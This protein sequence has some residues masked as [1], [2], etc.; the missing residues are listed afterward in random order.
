MAKGALAGAKMSL[1]IAVKHA[2]R[3]RQFNDSVKIQEDLLL[4][5]P[6]HQLRLLPKVATS[7][8]YE[9]A[10]GTAMQR[11]AANTSDD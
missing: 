7:Y 10:L 3:R 8:V 5:Y 11:Y 2:L 4:D 9:I 6:T 1:A